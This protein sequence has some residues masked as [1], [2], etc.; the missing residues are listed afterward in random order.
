MAAYNESNT[1]CGPVTSADAEALAPNP[2][3]ATLSVLPASKDPEQRTRMFVASACTENTNY[4]RVTGRYRKR[5]DSRFAS[6]TL[7]CPDGRC[8]GSGFLYDLNGAE[9]TAFDCT[10]R[11]SGRMARYVYSDV[12]EYAFPWSRIDQIQYVSDNTGGQ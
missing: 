7:A 8:D 10:C 6:D 5:F 1:F 4:V 12:M 2:V 9:R 3:V 11:T